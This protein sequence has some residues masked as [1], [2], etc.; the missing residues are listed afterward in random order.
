MAHLKA[1]SS[2]GDAGIKG[3]QRIQRVVAW[4]RPFDMKTYSFSTTT[5]RLKLLNS[6]RA[7]E[8]VFLNWGRR[9]DSGATPAAASGPL[10]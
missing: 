2:V 6:R 8:T 5:L 9:Q 3:I 4:L 10:N 1:R 7:P